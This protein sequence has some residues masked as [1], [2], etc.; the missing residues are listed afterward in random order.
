MCVSTGT[1]PAQIILTLQGSSW[2][3][4]RMLRGAGGGA[5]TD[6]LLAPQEPWHAVKG[7]CG[8]GRVGFAFA[9]GVESGSAILPPLLPPA[10]PPG[11]ASTGKSVPPALFPQDAELHPPGTDL[12]CTSFYDKHLV[13]GLAPKGANKCWVMG[14][15]AGRR[16]GAK[17]NQGSSDSP[18]RLKT[19][20]S[21]GLGQS[22]S[23]LRNNLQNT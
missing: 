21:E 13:Q 23:Q 20:P 9:S 17:G 1:G 14:R 16:W 7:E 10:Y 22:N 11:S 6:P 19:V 12:P 8:Q 3:Q 18:L 2:P 5:G 4:P 15:S